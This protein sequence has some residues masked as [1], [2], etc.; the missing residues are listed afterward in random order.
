M[1]LPVLLSASDKFFSPF[2]KRLPDGTVSGFFGSMFRSVIFFVQDEEAIKKNSPRV[3]SVVFLMLLEF[4]F[5]VKPKI[6]D[7]GI[8]TDLETDGTVL[9]ARSRLYACCAADAGV[10]LFRI[11]VG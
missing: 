2:R 6:P 11:R 8:G 5:Y 1:P 7:A 9:Y 10:S 4:Y 3:Y